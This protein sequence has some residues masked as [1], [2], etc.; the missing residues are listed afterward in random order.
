MQPDP[1]G[2]PFARHGGGRDSQ[3]F[4]GV[5]DRESPEEAQFHD[6][7]LL[8]VELSQILQGFVEHD[9]IEI[10]LRRE[11]GTLVQSHLAGVSSTLSCLVTT[12]ILDQ[13]LAHE[14][15]GYSEKVRAILP[16]GELMSHQSVVCFMNESCA[17]QSM[18]GTYP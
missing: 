15:G 1:C 13:N 5:V 7:A 14:T 9:H 11:H 10:R 18:V 2:R 12:C 4:R 16:L 8:L 17:L 3:H 6:P